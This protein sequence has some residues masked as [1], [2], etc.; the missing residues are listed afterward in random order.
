M[1]K[2]HKIEAVESEHEH[3]HEHDHQQ[4]IMEYQYLAQQ[5]QQLQQTYSTMQKHLDELKRLDMA[6]S[7]L[8]NTKK[9]TPTLIPLGS[10][11]Y[12]KGVLE[13]DSEIYMNVGSG[14]VV[15][16]S[17]AHSLETV[18]KQIVEV[19]NFMV[20]VEQNIQQIAGRLQELQAHLQGH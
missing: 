8:A 19:E 5:M 18:R 9:G 17:F 10:G 15:K 20:Q 4:E 12:V 7:E 16:K 11:I 1:D 14:V 3:I 2:P 6:V 13:G